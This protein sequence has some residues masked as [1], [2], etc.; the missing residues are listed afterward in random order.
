MSQKFRTSRRT[1]EN[2]AERPKVSQNFRKSR[3]TSENLAEIR[4]ILQNFVTILLLN[5]YM[6]F[7]TNQ[8]YDTFSIVE[9]TAIFNLRDIFR[10]LTKKKPQQHNA[11]KLHCLLKRVH[12]SMPDKPS[13]TPRSNYYLIFCETFQLTLPFCFRINQRDLT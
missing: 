7:L 9:Q 11:T 6:L 3:G 2:P 10:L 8:Y 13:Q 12:I 5:S 4:K 1:P